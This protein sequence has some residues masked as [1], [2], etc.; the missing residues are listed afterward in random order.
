MGLNNQIERSGVSKA[1]SELQPNTLKLVRVKVFV[2]EKFNN[3]LRNF[4]WD[5]FLFSF[6]PQLKYFQYYKIIKE[7][8]EMIVN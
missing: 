2:G 1:R 4:F 6:F 5:K 8:E 3:L 7:K